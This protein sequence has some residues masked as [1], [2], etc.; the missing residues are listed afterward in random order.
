MAKKDK[1]VEELERLNSLLYQILEELRQIKNKLY[2]PNV[3]TV[4]IK[5][6]EAPIQETPALPNISD[7]STLQFP[8]PKKENIISEKQK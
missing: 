5:H 3:G 4:Q 7:N 1:M 8:L 6:Y 2:F